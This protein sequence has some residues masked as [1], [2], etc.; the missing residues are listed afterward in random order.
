M[1]TVFYAVAA[2]NAVPVI[3]HQK[4]MPEH[5]AALMKTVTLITQT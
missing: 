3:V 2:K 5:G 1:G 4:R